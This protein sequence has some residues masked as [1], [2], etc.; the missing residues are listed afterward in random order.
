MDQIKDLRVYKT[1]SALVNAM[2]ELITK[3]KFED[4][5]VQ[6]LCDIAMVRRA[7]FYLNFTDKLDLFSFY[8]KIQFTNFPTYLKLK[9]TNCTDNFLQDLISDAIHYLNAH[10]DMV[11]MLIRSDSMPLMISII[12]DVIA[13]DVVEIFHH[14]SNDNRNPI[15]NEIRARFYINGFFSTYI[16][17]TKETPS[18]SEEDFIHSIINIV[19]H[20]PW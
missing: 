14:I 19:Y 13:K 3:K 4:I 12:T 6:N 11:N 5:T 16:W 1:K 17:Y 18:I 9:E 2:H 7:T 15:Q 10:S 8:T 20:S